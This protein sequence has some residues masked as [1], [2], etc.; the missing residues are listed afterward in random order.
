MKEADI[1]KEV[2][3]SGTKAGKTGG[4]LEAVVSKIL[5]EKGFEI[6]QYSLYKKNPSLYEDGEILL[7]NVPYTSIYNHKAKTEFLL[8]SKKYGLNIRIECKWQQS[9][10]SVDEKF[11][12]LYL[13]CV[14]AMPE[15]DIFLIVDGGGYKEGARNWLK[16]AVEDKWQSNDK[17]IKLMNLSEFIMWANNHFI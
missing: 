10:G 14:Q 1:L 16:R 6:I 13:N 9:S 3:I 11:P 7:R 4:T 15:K 5:E 12:Y 17:N 2:I 8:K